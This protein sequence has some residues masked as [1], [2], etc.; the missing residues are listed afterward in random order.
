M[1]LPDLSELDM[2][3]NLD[4]FIDSEEK[5]LKDNGLKRKKNSDMSKGNKEKKV[6]KEKRKSIIPKT[7][8]NEEGNPVLAIPD[9]NDIDLNGEINRFFGNK[10]DDNL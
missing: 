1:K 10:E 6:K 4:E 5:E 9:L 7:E 8:Y 3:S 2:K